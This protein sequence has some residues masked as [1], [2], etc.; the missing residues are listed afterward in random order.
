MGTGL[1]SKYKR[2][3]L[4][5]ARPDHASIDGR[6]NQITLR[7]D[8]PDVDNGTLPIDEVTNALQGF[9]GAY[10]KVMRLR[11]ESTDHE[12]RLSAVDKGSF[13]LVILTWAVLGQPPGA[14]QSLEMARCC[15]LD[16]GENFH[17]R[18]GAFLV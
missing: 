8:G 14:L 3:S 13:E 1:C 4:P 11:G 15:T 9:S 6:R 7:Y 2:R 18:S 10:N 12:L 17:D 5:D 16:N